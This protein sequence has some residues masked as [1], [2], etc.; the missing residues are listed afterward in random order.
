MILSVD[1]SSSNITAF[2]ILLSALTVCVLS[3]AG[4]LALL[5]ALQELVLR[6][7]PA[8][9][10]WITKFPPLETMESRLFKVN[11]L[12]FILL[13]LVLATSFYFYHP[14]LWEYTLLMQKTLLTLLA[15]IL[16]LVL[17]IGRHWQGWRG[18]QAIYSTLGGVGLLLIVY[19][20][21][22]LL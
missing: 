14:L 1:I 12:G 5:L 18:P 15:W 22:K 16:F 11:G 20:V 17:L 9:G 8:S 10:S 3:V 19:G 21:S 13:S 6:Y 2:H 7:K 4:L